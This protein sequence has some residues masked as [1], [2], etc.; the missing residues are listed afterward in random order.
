MTYKLLNSTQEIE[1]RLNKRNYDDRR[2][3]LK[4]LRAY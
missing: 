2:E 1:V 4:T 3:I